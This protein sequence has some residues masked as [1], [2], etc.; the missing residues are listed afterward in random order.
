MHS[1]ERF[2]FTKSCAQSDDIENT[3]CDSLYSGYTQNDWLEGDET[4]DLCHSES[5]AVGVKMED[6][7]ASAFQT[8]AIM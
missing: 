8:G 6:R 7:M 4:G 1:D 5:T 2:T 3:T